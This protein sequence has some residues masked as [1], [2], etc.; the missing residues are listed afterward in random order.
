MMKKSFLAGIVLA[1]AAIGLSACGSEPAQQAEAA[2]EGMPGVEVSKARLVLPAVKGNPG[3]LYF[4]LTYDGERAAALRG[5]DVAGAKGATM[6]QYVDL[7]GEMAMYELLPQ[8][9]AKGQTL[10]F[11]PGGYHIMVDGLDEGIAAGGTVEATLIFAG[12]DKSS[13]P[14]EVRAAGEDR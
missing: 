8:P 6:H 4:D 11:E 2:P 1:T 7:S 9:L 12:G 13:F 10:K 3:V 14:V 5:V